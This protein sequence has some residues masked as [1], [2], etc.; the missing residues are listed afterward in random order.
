MIPER[1]MRPP[2]SH[3]P[4][5]AEKLLPT[6]IIT[7]STHSRIHSPQSTVPHTATQQKRRGEDYGCSH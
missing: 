7:Q 2:A 3:Q 6:A 5:N 4:A 1:L